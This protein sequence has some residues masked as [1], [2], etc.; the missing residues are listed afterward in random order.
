MQLRHGLL[1]YTHRIRSFCSW[2][3]TLFGYDGGYF[4]RHHLEVLAT[5]FTSDLQFSLV[6]NFQDDRIDVSGAKG[7]FEVRVFGSL[8]LGNIQENAVNL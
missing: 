2:I 8:T 6:E 3:D 1:D 4:A 5:L 7:G